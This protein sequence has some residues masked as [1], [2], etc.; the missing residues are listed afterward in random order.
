[1]S[2]SFLTLLT[3]V[4]FLH[5]F[6]EVILF[7]GF[8]TANSGQHRTGKAIALTKFVIMGNAHEYCEVMCAEIIDNRGEVVFI[9]RPNNL[10]SKFGK[11]LDFLFQKLSEETKFSFFP[12]IRFKSYFCDAPI[13]RG[14][15]ICFIF[16]DSNAHAGDEAFLKHIRNKFR[17]KLVLYAMNPSSVMTLSPEFCNHFYDSIFTVFAHDADL[18]RWHACKHIYSKIPRDTAADHHDGDTDVFFAG[19]DKNRLN[20]ILQTYEFLTHNG[21]RCDFHIVGVGRSRMH[22]A[23]DINYNHWLPYKELLKRMRRS[24]CI[25]EILQEPGVG[26]TLRMAEAVV[27]NKKI[28]T[29]DAA[30]VSHP[31]YDERFVKVFDAPENID[32]NFIRNGM[33]PDYHYRGEYSAGDFLTLVAE[34]LAAGSPLRGEI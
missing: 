29:N 21:I 22:R 7:Q 31:F 27:Y 18:Y 28:L 12:A 33:V 15:E 1:M 4:F 30:A 9:N 32:L 23:G 17:A 19:R 14:S 16:F 2:T 26:P 20:K 13:S 3:F 34:K 11:L 24:R 5:C 10:K 25:L 8:H 6:Q